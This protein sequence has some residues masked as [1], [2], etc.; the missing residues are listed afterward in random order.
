MSSI[1]L[2]LHITLL[3][4]T[5]LSKLGIYICLVEYEELLYLNTQNKLQFLRY[6]NGLILIDINL[7][8]IGSK[9]KTGSM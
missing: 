2:S 6:L 9:C 5:I 8:S 1:L 4:L 3:R 7:S